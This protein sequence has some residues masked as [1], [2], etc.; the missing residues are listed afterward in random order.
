VPRLQ[1]KL[2]EV[3]ESGKTVVLMIDE[4][5]LLPPETLEFLRL[6]SNFETIR[7]S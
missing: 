5:Q 2:L 6:L 7:K 3:F 1:L 4:A